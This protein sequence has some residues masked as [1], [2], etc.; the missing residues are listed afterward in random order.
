MIVK[1]K[2]GGWS[3]KRATAHHMFKTVAI[4]VGQQSII[5][6]GL[7]NCIIE[8]KICYYSNSVL[9]FYMIM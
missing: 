1:L 6:S 5:V 3:S 2:G 8:N 4:T 7:Y 9:I